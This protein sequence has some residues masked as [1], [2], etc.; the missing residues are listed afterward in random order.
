MNYICNALSLNMLAPTV[1]A[2]EI[3]KVGQVE[4]DLAY[5]EDGMDIF[6]LAG[7]IPAVGDENTGRLIAK[8]FRLPLW[9]VLPEDGSRPTITLHPGDWALVFQYSGPRLPE[10]AVSLPEGA[11]IVPCV[12][13]AKGPHSEEE[14]DY[15][16]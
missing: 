9:A 6:S 10:G 16:Y 13:V 2:L 15:V 12:V 4:A 5:G 3:I 1:T 11:V 8:M 14:G 7:A